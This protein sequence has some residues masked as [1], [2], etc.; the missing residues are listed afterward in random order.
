VMK[1]WF[2]LVIRQTHRAGGEAD[3]PIGERTRV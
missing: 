2:R 1:L 3:E